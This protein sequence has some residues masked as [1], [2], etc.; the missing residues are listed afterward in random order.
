[1]TRAM[2][3]VS[4]SKFK[5]LETP[6]KMGRAYF[7]K[8]NSLFASV[9]SVESATTNPFMVQRHNAPIGIFVL[10]A[11]TGLCG[12]YNYQIIR[13]VEKFIEKNPGKDIRLYVYGRKGIGAFRKKGIS[14]VQ[15]FPGFHGKLTGNFHKN[16]LDTLINDFL[17]AKVSEIHVAYTVFENAMKHHPVVQKFLSVDKPVV[18]NSNFIVEFTHE[19]M[20]D[21]L[22]PL[23]LSSWFRLMILESLTSEHSA[24]MVA[25]KSSKDNAKELMGDLVLLRNKVRQASITKEVIEIISSVEALK[26]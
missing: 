22:M 4:M 17:N 1:M 8:I 6:L 3:M 10:T 9:A 23:Y 18:K 15:A 11:D 7:N 19:G 21:E 12:I 20:L 13:A 5:T 26:G 16:I 25:M 2:E 24:R 14:I